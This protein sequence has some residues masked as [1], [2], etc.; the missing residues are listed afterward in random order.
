MQRSLSWRRR[1][2][3]LGAISAVTLAVGTPGA[4]TAVT[5]NARAMASSITYCVTSAPTG[6]TVAEARTLLTNA[7]AQWHGPAGLAT[8][9][10]LTLTHHNPCQTGTVVTISAA[11][12]GTSAAAAVTSYASPTSA[13][14]SLEF[15]SAY[16]WWNGSGTR[17]SAAMSYQG[18]L[19]HEM[20]HTIG[21]GHSGGPKWSMDNVMPTMVDSGTPAV[22]PD[23]TTIQRDDAS[24]AAF[25]PT[26]TPRYFTPNAGFED[27]WAHWGRTAGTAV[28]SSYAYTGSRGIRVNVP[29]DYVYTSVLYDPYRGS[30]AGTL[31][32]NMTTAVTYWGRAY[33]RNP[34][35]C[36]SR[37][38]DMKYQ[39]RYLKYDSGIQK[40]VADGSA[41]WTTWSALTNAGGCGASSP[42]GATGWGYCSGS[43]SLSNST[44]N[45]ATALQFYF[46]G[47]GTSGQADLDQAGIMFSSGGMS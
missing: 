13:T 20:G 1:T 17:P 14:I 45:D 41:T 3:W 27:D 16:S 26:A 46:Y 8:N 38:F 24:M 11:N 44:T 18:V 35:C 28:S 10:A 21:M 7:I 15:N 23:M 5:R 6:V 36:Q 37:G 4:A 32:P 2:R 25:L 43:V 12:R 31:A 47:R 30:S 33:F 39:Y 22:T 40:S 9:Q 34:T 42:S 29:N 19:T